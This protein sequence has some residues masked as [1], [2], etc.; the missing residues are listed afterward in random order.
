MDYVA[1]SLVKIVGNAAIAA[2]PHIG[3]GGKEEGDQ[4]AVDA[5]RAAF[6]GIEIDAIV[7]VGEGEKDEAPML[8]VGEKL[9]V[10]T[11]LKLDIAVDP[12]EGTSLMAAGKPNAI[13]VIAVTEQNAFWDAGDAYYM[14]KIVVGKEASAVIDIN[15]SI[16]QNLRAIAKAKGKRLNELTIYVL[17][18]P[19]HKGLIEEIEALGSIVALHDEGDVIGSVLA[20]IDNGGVDA[21][22]GIGGAP[23]AVITAAAVKAIGGGMQ[24]KLVPQKDDEK[25][26]LIDSG[27]DLSKVLYLD[28][29]INSEYAV[30]AAAGVTTG[31]LLEGV[32]L[33]NNLYK[34][35]V[36]II[37][38]NS[39][40]HKE[41]FTITLSEC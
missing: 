5:M 9:G 2:Y 30:F 31:P 25:V 3:T 39:G 34:T 19:R 10:G 33:E 14:N 23:E 18:K 8:Y 29:L 26:K 35:E 12:I 20:L 21:L 7:R 24:G 32:S 11:G 22:M 6:E 15:A 17:N 13:A 38:S 40:I 1:K 37:D 36:I 28:D 27:I 4:A 16:D 41:F